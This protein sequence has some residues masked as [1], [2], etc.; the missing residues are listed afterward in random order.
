VVIQGK[1]TY[2]EYEKNDTKHQRAEIVASEL[3][4]AG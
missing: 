2:N 1:L 3:Y 4:V